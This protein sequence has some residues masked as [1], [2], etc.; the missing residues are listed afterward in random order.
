MTLPYLSKE[1]AKELLGLTRQ[2]SYGEEAAQ[3]HARRQEKS[4]QEVA[5]RPQWDGRIPR[6]TTSAGAKGFMPAGLPPRQKTARLIAYRNTSN[7]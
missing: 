4:G 3:P 2:R 1:E 6:P 7:L 5:A